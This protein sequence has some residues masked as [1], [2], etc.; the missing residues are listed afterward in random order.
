[1][2]GLS[3]ATTPAA[4][5]ARYRA[6][7]ERTVTKPD[8]FKPD[9]GELARTLQQA[10]GEFDTCQAE[11]DAAGKALFAAAADFDQAVSD[12]RQ[13]TGNG[14]DGP[15]VMPDAKTLRAMSGTILTSTEKAASTT[16]RFVGAEFNA[17]DWLDAQEADIPGD[18]RAHLGNALGET[19]SENHIKL[20]P[21]EYTRMTVSECAKR[22]IPGP[23][24]ELGAV[25]LV[26]ATAKVEEVLEA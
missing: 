10:K 19:A 17:S 13:R 22:G 6:A 15:A 12:L 21:A 5:P 3:P 1:M 25:V 7:K 11:Y 23:P 20:G 18:L 24:K 2:R 9:I 26:V 16:G 8:N 14:Q 4:T